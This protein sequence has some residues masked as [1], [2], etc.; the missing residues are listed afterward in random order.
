MSDW[1][2][3]FSREADLK[4]MEALLV[5]SP[6]SVQARYCRAA[7]LAQLGRAEESK[8]AFLDVLSRAPT[9]FGALVDFGNLLC[10]MGFKQ[11]ARTLYAEAVKHHPE[12]PIAHINLGNLLIESGEFERAQE[13]FETALRLAPDSEGA[14]RGLAHLYTEMRDE[15]QAAQY[16]EKGF[17]KEPFLVMPY[18]GEGAPIELLALVSSA[19][20][21]IPIRHHIDERIYQVTLLFVE[22][23]DGVRPLPPHRLVINVIGDPDLCGPALEAAV[24]IVGETDAPVIN[25]P[26]RVL[27]TGRAENACTLDRLPDVVTPKMALLPR[28]CLEGEGAAHRLAA[29]GFAFPL[30]LRA[31]GFHTGRYFLRVDDERALSVGVASLPGA[32]ILAIQYVDT[33]RADGKIRKYRVMMIGGV[34]Y[35]LHAAVSHDWKIHYFT[36]EMADNPKHR[37]EDAAFLEN[38][39]GVLGPRAVQALEEI[40]RTLG[41]D[42][43]GMDFSV[44]ADGEVVL[45]EANASMVVNAPDQDARWDY[46]RP[47]VQRV[48]DAIR[49]LIAQRTVGA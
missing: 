15:T 33:R 10:G 30:L 34:L 9:H 39:A 18:Y 2:P 36:A 28:A 13:H 21:V 6:D 42:Y 32:E 47:A 38:M 49:A 40:C 20:G 41:L 44:N 48:M 1:Q 16:R 23:Y 4:K 25:H 35:P 14:N 5:E 11:A 17:Q 43:G 12:N 3:R 7:L 27:R 8:A 24:K 22:H 46:R 26:A 37:A 29:Q 19:G 45:F 31:P